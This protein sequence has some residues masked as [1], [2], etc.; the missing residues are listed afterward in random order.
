MFNYKLI[1]RAVEVLGCCS[2]YNTNRESLIQYLDKKEEQNKREKIEKIVLDLL[3]RQ[4]GK[5]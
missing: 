4:K 1:D 3:G 5:K 2:M